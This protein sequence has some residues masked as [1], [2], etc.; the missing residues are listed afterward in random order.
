LNK[1]LDTI[2]DALR[3]QLLVDAIV[4]YAIYML[5]LNGHV[6]SWNSGAAR[7]KGYTTEEITGRNFAVFYTPEDRA[8]GLPRKA[9]QTA[10][11]TGRF[12]AEGWRVRKDG[13][14]F[15]ALV[16]I[17]AIRDEAG[18][19]IGFA[20]VTRDITERQAAH[21]N[22]LQSE[23][24]YRRLIEAVIDYAIFQLDSAGHIATW[25]PGA[26]QIK[27]YA[28][29]EIIGKHFSIFYT[30]EDRKAQVP[31]RALAEAAEKGR[32]ESE[33][34]RVRKDGSTFWASVVIDRIQDDSGNLAGFAKV[35][36]DISDRKQAQDRLKEV[37]AQLVAS[38]KLEAVGQF[39]YRQFGDCRAPL[40]PARRQWQSCPGP[41]SRQAGSPA[42]RRANQPVA[43][44]FP[45]PAP[46]SQAD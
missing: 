28:P 18:E 20:K 8:N 12:D 45:A 42:R 29:E 30:D 2:S 39:C 3:L 16:V 27:G 4:D 15:W 17:D 6:V 7:L 38:Q 5:D 11:E 9:L 46:G 35:T 14:R 33:G 1:Q 40:A 26:K 21:E 13:S 44:V 43:G 25:N 24:R 31:E 19:I 23:R 22:L 41:F 32:F 37:Q 36:R 10:R 34:W